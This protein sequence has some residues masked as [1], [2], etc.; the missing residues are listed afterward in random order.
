MDT[1]TERKF[2]SVD[3]LRRHYERHARGHWF[4][5]DTMRMFGTRLSGDTFAEDG[6]VFITSEV[7]WGDDNRTY[8]VR[9]YDWREIP[10]TDN[11]TPR[12]TIETVATFTTLARAKRY[13]A[14]LTLDTLRSTDWA[15]HDGYE[16]LG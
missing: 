8:R 16:V 2:Y 3:E 12:G 9:W 6:S 7:R 4:S 13:A 1:T 10:N 14:G 11:D 15:S 5:A